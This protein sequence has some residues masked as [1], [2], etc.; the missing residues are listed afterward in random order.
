MAVTPLEQG[1]ASWLPGWRG[2]RTE[3]RSPDVD[4][5]LRRRRTQIR[6]LRRRLVAVDLASALTVAGAVLGGGRPLAAAMALSVFLALAAHSCTADSARSLVAVRPLVKAAL[7]LSGAAC[8]LVAVLATRPAGQEVL[9]GSLV[10]VLA[11]L[12][13]RLLAR[14]PG[15]AAR[16]GTRGQ[17]RLLVGDKQALE[18]AAT[19]RRTSATSREILVVTRA[20]RPSADPAQDP[21]VAERPPETEQRTAYDDRRGPHGL[22]ERVVR[23]ALETGAERVTV[24]PGRSWGQPQ[25][26]ELSWL[27]EGTGIDMVISTELDGIAPHRVD[28]VSQDGRLM[29]K[30]GSANPRGVRALLKGILDRLVALVLLVLAAPALLAIGVAI[31]AESA[32]PAIFRQTRVREG[33]ATFTMYKFRTMRLG[34][35]EELG[36]L[37]ELSM[38]GADKPLFKLQDDPRVT[39]VGEVLRRTS[40]DELPQLVNVLKGQMSLI[41]PRPA[42]PVEVAMYDFVARRRLAVKPGMTGLWQV[43]GRSRLRW[44]ESIG[45]DLEYVDNWSAAADASIAI[46]TFRAVMTRDGAY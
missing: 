25:L 40:L 18:R 32:G 8:A 44:D 14:L 3:A 6:S 41:G 4:E 43:S 2:T 11:L 21:L 27:L 22:V 9:L 46:R 13:V 29:I 5:R 38:H 26:R 45:F 28:V 19:R 1:L 39:R 36:G 10:L 20:E 7:V 23:T 17:S 30:V 34:A 35:E 24:I 12:P 31:R 16:Y 37:Q 33:G 42:L 15:P